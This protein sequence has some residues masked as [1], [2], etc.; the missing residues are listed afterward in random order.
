MLARLTLLLTG[1]WAGMVATVGLVAAPA[2]FAVLD[3]AQ[4]GAVVGHVFRTEAH[5]SLALAAVV[6]LI[7]RQLASQAARQHRGSGFSAGMVLALLALFCT[8]AGYFAVQPM[9]GAARA[10]QGAL[11]FAALHGISLAFF[12]A[13]GLALLALVWIQTGRV[14]KQGRFSSPAPFS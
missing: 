6:V 4:A 12:G 9:M 3:R 5:A 14:T 13:K 11:S 2:A 1:M 8:V 7:E 10:G